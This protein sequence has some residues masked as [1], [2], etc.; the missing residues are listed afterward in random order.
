[1]NGLKVSVFRSYFFVQK[2]L[3]KRGQKYPKWIILLNARLIY[4]TQEFY[5]NRY[6]M[7]TNSQRVLLNRSPLSS[8][9]LKNVFLIVLTNDW[10]KNQAFFLNK[11]GSYRSFDWKNTAVAFWFCA[12]GTPG[13]TKLYISFH[14]ICNENVVRLVKMKLNDI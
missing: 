2:L 14:R 12:H 4:P 1:M 5:R 6:R 11:V 8:R 10:I 9:Y 13:I 7:E 3:R